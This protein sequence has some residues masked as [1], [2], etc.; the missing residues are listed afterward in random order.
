MGLGAEDA[1]GFGL[2]LDDVDRIRSSNRVPDV[3]AALS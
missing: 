3:C 2:V 1:G